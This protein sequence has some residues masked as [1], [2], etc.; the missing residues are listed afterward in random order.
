LEQHYRFERSQYGHSNSEKSEASVQSLFR[1][2]LN[3]KL[4]EASGL[5]KLK[6]RRFKTSS[7]Y[8]SASRGSYLG[9]SKNQT[10]GVEKKGTTT[11]ATSK[12]IKRKGIRGKYEL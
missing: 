3:K 11:T 4:S 2:N 7:T 12:Q 8:T 1:D 9:Y 6:P 5:S 10:H